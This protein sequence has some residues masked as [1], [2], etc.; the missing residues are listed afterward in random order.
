MSHV[1]T[2]QPSGHTVR[3]A[4]DRSILSSGLDAG[5]LLPF[6]CRSGICQ[7][8][9]GRVV[10]GEVDV[11]DV[12]P[13]YLSEAERADGFVHLCQARALSDC[14]IEIEE[15]DP[16][17]RVPAESMP[18]RVLGMRKLAPDVMAVRL[19]TPLNE[20]VKFHAGQYLDI[21]VEAG[22]RRSYSLAV[23]PTNDGLR[24]LELHIRHM[25]GGRFTDHVFNRMQLR[26]VLQIVV[27][28]GV[29]YLRESDAP[30]I[31]LCSGTGFAPIKSIVEDSIKRGL[32]RPIHLYWGGRTREDIYLAQLAQQWASEH[33]HLKFIPV[34]S[35][36]TEACAWQGRTGFVHEAV[37][38]DWPNLV[39]H[40][41][42]ACGAPL[43]VEAARRSFVAEANLPAAHFFADSFVS[44]ADRA[45]HPPAHTE[46]A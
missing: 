32:R 1:V 15:Q 42:Y 12:H 27:P 21:E 41:V 5:L 43:M 26:D 25:P 46:T 36:A 18:A 28:Q 24:A 10:S 19:G 6:S 2:F 23:A 9:R 40:E 17:L 4:S 37:L 29:F 7:T 3:C 11:G 16:N 45:A 20:P 35:N 34:L 31:L 44:E 33:P 13:A 8:C 14:T 38:A 22:L 30:I 39:D